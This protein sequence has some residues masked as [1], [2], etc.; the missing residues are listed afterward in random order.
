DDGGAEPTETVTVT[1]DPDDDFEL[2]NDSDTVFIK[3]NDT[4]RV[5]WVSTSSADRSGGSNWSTNVEPAFGL[6]VGAACALVALV[7]NAGV[8]LF[9]RRGWP[10]S[11]R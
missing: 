11:S 8:V 3:D 9:S 10:G 2:G 4:R 5:Y 7:A 1:L 6:D